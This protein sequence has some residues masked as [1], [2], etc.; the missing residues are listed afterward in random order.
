MNTTDLPLA[1]AELLQT[2]DVKTARA[3]LMGIGVVDVCSRCGG[4]GRYSFNG[5]HSICYGCSGRGEFAASLSKRSTLARAVEAVEAGKLARYFV[6]RDARRAAKKAIAP[7]L[8]EIET[9]WN[10]VHAALDPVRE[11]LD[12]H[13]W[14]GSVAFGLIGDANDAH[15]AAFEVKLADKDPEQGALFAVEILAGVRARLAEI[16]ETIERLDAATLASRH[17]AP[18]TCACCG[19]VI[20]FMASDKR[21]TVRECSAARQYDGPCCSALIKVG[22]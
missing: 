5:T 9:I 11:S 20:E 6:A 8:A 18:Q 1:L 14:V 2:T 10:A 12:V 22:G 15:H 4:C 17:Y 19:S 13:A 7:L 16:A 3:R 21:G